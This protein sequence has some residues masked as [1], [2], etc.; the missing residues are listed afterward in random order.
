MR[1]TGTIEYRKKTLIFKKDTQ[2][3]KHKL[4]PKRVDDKEITMMKPYKIIEDENVK[5]LRVDLL[6][7]K[8]NAISA[9]IPFVAGV[10]MT[11]GVLKFIEA[12]RDLLEYDIQ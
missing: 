2:M 6:Q 11:W 4:N 9:A 8:T 3:K 12:R 7:L 1:D 5:E 10:L